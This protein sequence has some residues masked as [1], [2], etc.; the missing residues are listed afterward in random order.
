MM[1]GLSH[2]YH[3]GESIV[4]IRA[5]RSDFEFIFP[6]FVEIPLSQ[7]NSPILQHHIWGYIVCL[8]PIKRAPGLYELIIDGNQ[9]PNLTMY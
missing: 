6:L 1:N 3:L 2:C 7:Q 5:I 9:N 8:C 4:I